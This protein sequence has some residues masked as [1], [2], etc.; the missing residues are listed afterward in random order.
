VAATASTR[1]ELS[2]ALGRATSAT[3]DL[4][5]V[6]S[7]PAG[8]V[9]RLVLASSGLTGES[10]ATAAPRPRA[11]EAAS[12]ML[13][14]VGDGVQDGF[15]PLTGTARQAFGFLIGPSPAPPSAAPNGRG[16]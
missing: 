4:A 13:R 2:E 9:G 14:T 11:I 6:T 10:L 1:A 8:R 3:L 5:S 7:A 15:R 12:D 16:A